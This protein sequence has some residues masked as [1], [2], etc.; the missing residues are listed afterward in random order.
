MSEHA[1]R[2]VTPAG[3]P[4]PAG[5]GGA[6]SPAR[7]EVGL[8]RVW[9]AAAASYAAIGMVFQVLPPYTAAAGRA[10]GVSATAGLGMTVFLLP[11]P[12][13]AVPAGAF[14]DRHGSR[15][16]T[17]AG[18]AILLASAVLLAAVPGFGWLLA[19]RAVGGVG[20]GLVMVGALKMLAA[21]VPGPRAGSPPL[22]CLAGCGYGQSRRQGRFAWYQV[23]DPRVAGL[24]MLARS[25]AAGNAPALGE[26][27]RIAGARPGGP[28][29]DARRDQRC[30]A[31]APSRRPAAPG[32][33]GGAGR[34]AGRV[35]GGWHAARGRAVAG[36]PVLR[37]PRARRGRRRGRGRCGGR[38]TG[39]RLAAAGRRGRPARRRLPGVSPA[40][41]AARRS[42]TRLLPAVTFPRGRAGPGASEEA[43][44]VRLASRAA[45][46][47]WPV[48]AARQAGPGACFA[49]S[50]LY[51]RMTRRRRRE[52]DCSMKP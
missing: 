15:L 51:R 12:L 16:L 25:L 20:A 21:R 34:R 46:R 10:L 39:G 2:A 52:Y 32:G 41:P 22:A 9:L 23:A 40:G 11:V 37:W 18:F 30:P 44:A 14:C 1:R 35:R 42:G 5:A 7:P 4:G 36:G 3:L 29:C 31:D 8:P 6:A 50:R 19:A 26:C 24:V 17:R 28:G 47:R 27:V 48:C 38:G 43:A 33:R 13:L 45:G 49:G